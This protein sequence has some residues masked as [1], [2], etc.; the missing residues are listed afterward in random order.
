MLERGIADR[1]FDESAKRQLES[2]ELAD[3][4]R[5]R[6]FGI[7]PE[8]VREAIARRCDVFLATI[9]RCQHFPIAHHAAFYDNLWTLW[10]PL[11]MQL[12]DDRRAAGRPFVR[13]VLGGQGMGKT[14]LA[15]ML[16]TILAELGY[17]T[18]GLSIDD[19]YKTHAD[20][21]RLKAADPRFIRRGP[22]G[23]H[24]IELGIEVLDRLRRGETAPIAIPRFDKSL[25]NGDGDRA[26]PELVTGVDIIL[27]EGWFVGAQPVEPSAF[28]NP[29]HPIVTEADKAFARETNERLRDYLPLW[30]RIDRLMVLY[31][32]DYRLSLPWRQQAE[33]QAIA[34]GKAG[35]TDEEIEEFVGYF[36]KS[37]HPDLFIAPLVEDGNRVDLVVTV[38]PDRTFGQ[39]YRP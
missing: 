19:L 5:S 3:P 8:N 24:D 15:T 34:Q 32:T 36:W 20:R 10:L 31:P 7:S 9:D 4:L 2:W 25:W 27:F 1:R 37:L 21:Q 6:A 38:N 14:T 26:E 28:D 16:T 39:I 11:A 33:H 22:P 30:E 18:I 17:R 35:M 23:T 13:G 29:P 12:A